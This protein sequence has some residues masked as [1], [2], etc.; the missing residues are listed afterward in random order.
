MFSLLRCGSI[1]DLTGK[2]SVEGDG[3]V[4]FPLIG[5]TKVAGLTVQ[6]AEQTLHKLLADGYV[7]QPQVS[8]AVEHYRSQQIFVMGEV[9]TPA[10]LS[11]YWRTDTARGFGT[12]RRSHRARR[13]GDH[14]GAASE[15]REQLGAC[16]A[17]GGT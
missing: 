17:V 8:I 10:R 9:K 2:F 11:V 12:S 14:G 13:F 4:G 7:K 5:R 16:T 3:T 1:A 15:R 6:Q